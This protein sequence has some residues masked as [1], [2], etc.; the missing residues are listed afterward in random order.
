M[1]QG[2]LVDHQCGE[3]KTIRDND[4]RIQKFCK[5][6][7]FFGFCDIGLFLKNDLAQRGYKRGHDRGAVTKRGA[8]KFGI[9][10]CLQ[11]WSAQFDFSSLMLTTMPTEMTIMPRI[12]FQVMTS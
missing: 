3:Q 7:A 9:H 11:S 5:E 12:C 8:E 1:D 4:T 10:S 2:H 6:S